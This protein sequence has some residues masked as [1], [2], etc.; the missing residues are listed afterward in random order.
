METTS[1]LTKVRD[2]RPKCIWMQAKV[3]KQKTCKSDY[4][5]AECRFDRVMRHVARENAALTPIDRASRG[6]KGKI[7]LWK[8]RL[9]SL[10]VAKRPCIHSMKGRI[11]FRTCTNEYR[12]RN[13]DFDQYFQD[14]FSVH[15]VVNPVNILDIKGFRVPQGYYFHHGHTW[16]KMEENTLVRI[17]IDDFILRLMGPVDRV[18]APLLG[19]AVKQGR[20]DI[21]II[22]GNRRAKLLSPISGVVTAVNPKLREKGNLA[23]QEPYTEGWVMAVQADRL[24][25]DIQGLMLNRETGEFMEGQ[26]EELY[27]MI[28]DVAG[29]LAADGGHLGHDIFGSMPELGWKRLQK[30]F[31]HT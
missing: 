26:V 9:K 27:H 29:P 5:C 23:S 24:R 30:T 17:G 7:V 20:A 28:E 4:G 10:P 31:L 25:R 19:K 13:C 12:C 16:V 8:E 2:G 21:T 22:R 3:V 15:A 18:E 1:M 11:A 6:K 14:Q